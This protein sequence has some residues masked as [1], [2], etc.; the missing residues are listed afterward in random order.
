[1][2]SDSFVTLVDAMTGQSEVIPVDLT[3]TTV[4]QV[5]ELAQALLGSSSRRPASCLMR[6][7]GSTIL[8]SETDR[9]NA[10]NTLQQANVA[11][12]DLLVV[13]PLP[14]LPHPPPRVAANGGLDFSNLLSAAPLP[15]INSGRSAS[16]SGATAAPK[17][18]PTPV[19]WSGMDLHQAQECNPNPAAFVPLLLEKEHLWKELHHH[20]AKLAM[21]M[22]QQTSLPAAIE[23]WRAQ[24]V[25][26]AVVSNQNKDAYQ[27][28][29]LSLVRSFVGG[30]SGRLVLVPAVCVVSKK[31]PID[32]C[33]SSLKT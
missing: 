3:S 31:V 20:N 26:G 18:E 2:S 11:S 4:Q 10:T 32:L 5:W 21:L 13:S 7:D 14:Q 30:T 15:P 27:N 22:R 16:S 8:L 33:L 17:P 9:D 6:D 28:L 1:M 24:I 12:G 25:Q 29:S 19:Y 23:T